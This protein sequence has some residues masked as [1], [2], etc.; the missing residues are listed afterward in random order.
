MQQIDNYIILPPGRSKNLT[1]QVY[2]DYSVLYRTA[3]PDTSNSK[4]AHW[5]CQCVKCKKYLIKSA[6]TLRHGTNECECNTDLTDKTFGRL[7]VQYLVPERTKK[8]GKI[9]HCKCICG[10]EKN[11]PAETLVRGESNSCGCLQKEILINS[12]KKTRLNIAG[13]RYGK[14]VALYP[15]YSKSKY[16]HTKWHCKCDCGV[17][18]DIDLGNLRQ[19][20]SQSCGCTHSKNEE[21]IIRLLTEHNISFNYQHRF[22]DLPLKEFDFF[23]DNKYVV[24]YDGSQHFTY[25]DRGWDTQEHFLRVRASDI[26]KNAYCFK[27]NIPIIR[28][29]YDAEYGFK[30]LQLETT[31]F[32]LTPNNQ[33][34]YYKK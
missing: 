22:S 12:H 24:E 25:S 33:E 31:R 15:I 29:P 10:N 26:E 21:K 20:F 8:R 7:T 16:I 2:G 14:L 18:C 19:G 27:R 6:Y 32:L 28:I 13:Q 30:D 5:L 1:G 34:K 11:I 17:E 23:I 4:Q 3:V 9:W